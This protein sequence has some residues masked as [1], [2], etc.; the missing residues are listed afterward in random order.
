MVE[1]PPPPA[2]PGKK[3]D[4][5]QPPPKTKVE[6]LQ[7]ETLGHDPTNL[8][9]KRVLST[10]D[11]SKKAADEGV[12]HKPKVP[13][14]LIDVVSEKQKHALASA[15]AIAL[16]RKAESNYNRH[17]GEYT[18]TTAGTSET[19][20]LQD[21]IPGLISGLELTVSLE[22]DVPEV[23]PLTVDQARMEALAQEAKT[24]LTEFKQFVQVEISVD[25]PVMKDGQPVMKADGTEPE[26]REVIKTVD[27][28]E[29]EA[30]TLERAK[31]SSGLTEEQWNDL[32]PDNRDAHVYKARKELGGKYSLKF[33]Q[34][35]S[36]PTTP[37]A[38]APPETETMP[39][40]EKRKEN[41]IRAAQAVE[42]ALVNGK[43]DK[44]RFTVLT[45]FHDLL[46]NKQGNQNTLTAVVT[47]TVRD[48]A[49]A[50]KNDPGFKDNST[51]TDALKTLEGNELFYTQ[52]GSDPMEA[53]T[54]DLLVGQGADQKLVDSVMQNVRDGKIRLASVYMVI[55]ELV[56]LAEKK[57]WEG[58]DRAITQKTG[59]E[60]QL[61]GEEAAFIR[62]FTKNA[63]INAIQNSY[64]T[65]LGIKPSEFTR[66]KD[67]LKRRKKAIKGQV[68]PPDH[69]LTKDEKKALDDYV[70]WTDK[71][72]EKI[73]ARA[74]G[75]LTDKLMKG[76]MGLMGI[77]MLLSMLQGTLGFGV[78]DTKEE[79]AG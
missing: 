36:E 72:I 34:P 13:N 9:W 76:G 79:A 35:S 52:Q 60:G 22:Q 64:A 23:R 49:L 33:E 41:A 27:Y 32:S 50:H 62:W 29:Y 28:A 17:T 3:P 46:Q 59:P 56:P 18:V 26:T 54:Q 48:L 16:A 45:L 58:L 24:A 31:T 69:K 51:L 42:Q 66:M 74:K 39:S 77:G 63:N 40:L 5:V 65:Q 67:Y 6:A 2:A 47:T 19:K 78:F 11:E 14:E 53:L 10:I 61:T 25:E 37:A 68:Y 30:L 7:P 75:S 55:S 38:E 1:T 8:A 44:D 4:L 57:D 21:S 12:L 15:E 20:K 71:D 73:K 43:I 70:Y